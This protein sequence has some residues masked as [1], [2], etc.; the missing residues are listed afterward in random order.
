MNV[1]CNQGFHADCTN[2]A[3]YF[4]LERYNDY[5]LTELLSCEECERAFVDESIKHKE[6]WPSRYI[7]FDTYE[8]LQVGLIKRRL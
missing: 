8:D 5:D 1:K 4:C 2:D 7:Y 3:A 6:D